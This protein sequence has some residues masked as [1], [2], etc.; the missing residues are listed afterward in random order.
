MVFYI[1]SW[2]TAEGHERGSLVGD[3]ESI[4]EAYWALS[5]GGKRKDIKFSLVTNTGFPATGLPWYKKLN[6]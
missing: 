3:A 4:F 5:E 1:L 2:F 6:N